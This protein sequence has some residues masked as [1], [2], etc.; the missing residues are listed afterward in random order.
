MENM[1]AVRSLRK[2]CEKDPLTVL[3]SL[4][5]TVAKS[6]LRS[7]AK[8]IRT[9]Q[10]IS[11]KKTGG[12][13]RGIRAVNRRPVLFEYIFSCTEG[14]F[15]SLERASLVLL[16]T[17]AQGN[18]LRLYGGEEELAALRQTGVSENTSLSED[19]VGTNAVG[20]CIYTRKAVYIHREEHY[21]DALSAYT[22]YGAPIYDERGEIAAVFGGISTDP[23]PDLALLNLFGQAA[24]SMGKECA[25]FHLKHD[26]QD[27]QTNMDCLINTMNYGVVLLDEQF[28]IVKANSVARYFFLMYEY[29]LAGQPI[30]AFISPQDI[31]FS[32][33]DHDIHDQDIRVHSGEV[34]EFSFLA[35]VYL[36]TTCDGEKNYL[37][38][39]NKAPDKAKA[40]ADLTPKTAK[41]RFNDIVGTDPTF[42][43]AINLAKIASKTSCTVLITGESGVGKELIAQ[44]IHNA[45]NCANGPFVAVNCGAIPK[46]LAESELFGYENGAFTGAKR[47]GMPGKFEL[48]NGGTIFLDEIGDMSM[49]LQ[50]CL[51]RFLQEQEVTRVGG[52][53]PIKV[54]V[55]VIAAT[56]KNLEEA[57][58]NAAFRMDL[59]YR[60]NVFNIHVPPLRER[61]GDIGNFSHY[62][63]QKYKLKSNQA[64]V[65]FTP[66]ALNA[67]QNY[68][69]PGNVRELENTIERAVIIARSDRVGL[70]D[71]P[72]KVRLCYQQEGLEGMERLAGPRQAPSFPISAEQAEKEVIIRAL[73]GAQGNVTRAAELVGISRRTLYRK[74]EKYGISK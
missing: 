29:E 5:E 52:K 1:A 54:N 11:A 2:A 33:L 73:R 45:S 34:K 43:E 35:S 46:S 69:W 47:T 44:A 14:I 40:T 66:E 65:G 72:E 30:T 28:R 74:M 60:L 24:N 20:T 57:I 18:V 62:F 6:W 58:N 10:P 53:Q 27:L 55:R 56:N 12:D 19:A 64:F 41:W 68:G 3:D 63:L 25:I 51:L 8:D 42:M 23:E 49:E 39:F 16:V 67:L 71:L 26:L 50:I 7:R 17:D 59:Y 31:D 21:K 9:Y 32:L 13:L 38:V 48:A 36:T 22:S 61:S 4:R 70:D 37:L 15:R